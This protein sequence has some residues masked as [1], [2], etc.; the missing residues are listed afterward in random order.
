MSQN[1]NIKISSEE[2]LQMISSSNILKDMIEELVMP[3]IPEKYRL[4]DMDIESI[5]DLRHFLDKLRFYGTTDLPDKLFEFLNLN[6]KTVLK[7]HRFKFTST[8][9]CIPV[10]F[11]R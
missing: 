11:H 2:L 5:E 4:E 6:F 3:S 10:F 7:V 1:K 9:W 8:Y